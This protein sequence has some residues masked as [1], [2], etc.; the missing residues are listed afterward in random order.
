MKKITK[1]LLTAMLLIAGVGTVNATKRYA[2]FSVANECTWN[3]GTNTMGFT[4]VNGWQI[5]WTGFPGGDITAYKKIHATLSGMSDNIGFVRLRIKDNS[6]HY[7]DVNLVTGENNIDLVALSVSNPTC[8]FTNINDITIWSPTSAA[9]GKVVDGEHPA[10]VTITNA[11][12]ESGITGFGNVITS[13]SGITDGTRFVISDNGTKAKYFYNSGSANENKNANVE[14]VPADAYCYFTLEKYTGGDVV[15]DNIYRIKITN[16]EDEGYPNGTNGGCYLNSLHDVEWAHVVI[17]APQGGWSCT[18]DALWYVTYDA[19]KGF[20]FQ[21][22]CRATNGK[23]LKSWLSIGNDLVAEQQYLKLYERIDFGV[24]TTVDMNVNITVDEE[25]RNYQLYVP[26]NVDEDCPLV[27]SLHGAN[28]GSTNYIPFTREV[29]AAQG[30]IVAYP[31]GKLTHFPIGFGGDATGWTA[32]GEDN[33]DV[34]FLK[35]VIED[36]ASKYQIDRKRIYCCGFSNGGMMTYAMANAC[37]N[38]IA[39]FASISGYPINEFHLRHTSSRPVPFLHIHGK[40]DNFVLYEKM[41]TI[42]DEMVARM[43][44]NPVPTTTTVGGKYTKSIYGAGDGSFPYVYYEVDGMGHEAFTNNTDDGNSAL[45]MWNF[46]KDYTLDSPSDE[47]LKWAPRIE[48]AGFPPTSHG[49]SMNDDT[50]LLSFGGAQYTEANK[51]VYASLQFESGTYKLCFHSTGDLGKTIGVRLVK[52][53]SPNTVVL[54]TTVNVGDDAKLPFEIT[55]GWGEYQ[56]TMTR[57]DAGDVISITDLAVIQTE[58]PDI[59][60]P[61]TLEFNQLGVATTDIADLYATGG[62]KYN[63]S[64]G[65]LTSDGTAGT[66][67]LAFATPV[68][69][70]YLNKLEIARTG[71]GDIV[72][73]LY[74]YEDDDCTVE[75]QSWSVSKWGGTTNDNATNAFRGKTIKKVVWKSAAGKS[76]SWTV[77]ISNITWTLKTISAVKGTDVTTLPFK[78][79]SADGDSDAEITGD[80]N[81][82]ECANNFN[83]LTSDVIYGGDG[84]GGSKRYVDLTDYSKLIIR[85][86]GTIRLFYNWH[87]STSGEDPESKPMEYIVITGSTVKTHELDLNAFKTAKGISHFHLVGVKGNGPCFVESLSVL[88]GSETADYTI[89]GIG[90]QLPSVA[91]VLADVDATSYDARGVSDTGVEMTAANPNALFRANA[92]VLSNANNVIVDGT[93]ANLALSDGYPFQAPADFTATAA[94]YNRSFTADKMTTVC[95]PFALTSDEASSLGTFYELSSVDGS[96]LTF[97]SVDAPLA[98]KAY[99]VKTTGTSLTLSETGKSIVATPADLSTTVSSIDFIGTLTSTTLPASDGTTDYY[100]FNN[101]S[102][103]KIVTNEATLPPFRAYF[104]VTNGGDVKAF[105]LKFEDTETGIDSLSPTPSPVSEGSIFNVAGQRMSK[106]QKGVNI[107]NGHKVLVK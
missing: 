27:I 26:A 81:Y 19:E 89:S 17:S 83:K 44:A 49:F 43:G 59:P 2:S 12:I 66:L 87:Q 101:G 5:L 78:N 50:T 32:T 99:L 6:D 46:F 88:D 84:I 79:W 97:T 102:L 94:S 95:L 80:I 98:N 15:G 91:A 1:L 63:P 67:V 82:W 64:T 92:G 40:A 37:S 3:S 11:Y 42:V 20:S 68:D 71:D 57:P 41:P 62:L 13:L 106:L 73:K 18:K 74:F 60:D 53:T 55:D 56:L 16:A 48:T 58:G 30:C 100:A 54:N 35:A 45:T 85:G 70:Q 36:V 69:L 21:N 24:N 105:N 23:G 107:L 93:C 8:D 14:D 61:T 52:L 96:T 34:E 31:Q 103:V 76:T 9:A 10:S 90:H 28:G 75:N 77:T 29:A 25:T 104:K 22:V 4:K 39:A 65:V 51:N 47:T 72:D 38:E 33:F 7:A 86:Y